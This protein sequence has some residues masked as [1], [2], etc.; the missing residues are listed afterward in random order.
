MS[1][2][3]LAVLREP[4]LSKIP[5]FQPDQVLEFVRMIENHAMLLETE[6]THVAVPVEED[7]F[8]CQDTISG[9]ECLRIPCYN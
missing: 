4:L 1:I 8:H 6:S 5:H 3:R 7:N 2:S 9:Q